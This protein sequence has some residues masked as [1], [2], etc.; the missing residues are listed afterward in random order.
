MSVKHK[1]SGFLTAVIV[2]IVSFFVI[3]IF[4]PEYSEKYL[5]TSIKTDKKAKQTITEKASELA[6]TA[7]DRLGDFINK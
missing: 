1:I 4:L 6:E 2:A 3:F 5:G 7:S